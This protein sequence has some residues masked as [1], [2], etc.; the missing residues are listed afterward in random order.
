MALPGDDGR[1]RAA[2]GIGLLLEAQ[3]R[4]DI[5]GADIQPVGQPVIETIE[6]GQRRF[7][8]SLVAGRQ[9][10]VAARGQFHAELALDMVQMLVGRAEQHMQ[11]GIVV[12]ILGGLEGH[13]QIRSSASVAPSELLCAAVMVSFCTLFSIVAGAVT[14]TD[15]I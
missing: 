9:H 15:C 1:D 13:A 6:R 14:N 8:Q 5:G 7:H 4:V 10:L 12:E 3:R 11:Q 2:G